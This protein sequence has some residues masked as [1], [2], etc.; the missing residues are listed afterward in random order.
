MRKHTTTSLATTGLLA[1]ALLVPAPAALADGNTLTVDVG[2][3]VRTVTRVGNGGLYALATPT[4][5]DPSL[6]PALH[7]NQL[8]QPPPGVQQLGNGATTPT[9]D[10]LKIGQT[11]V[12]AGAQQQ[13]RVPDIYPDFP[14]KWVSWDDLTA[15]VNT[16]VQQRLDRQDLTNVNGWELWN[17]PDWTWDTAKAGPF[18]DGFARIAKIVRAKDA[19]TPIVG[20]SFSKYDHDLMLSFMTAQKASGT[21]PDVAS[22]HELDDGG[23]NSVA[24]HVADYRAI[25]KQLGISPRPI[26]I[27]EYGS[28]NQVDDPSVAVHLV[29]AF[30]RSGVRDAERAY[31]YESGTIGGLIWNDKPTGSYWVYKW[32]ADQSGN[33]VKT[34]PSGDFDGVASYDAVR[35]TVNV[36]AGGVYGTNN[37]KINGLAPLGSQVQVTVNYTP[38]SGRKS[39]VDAP[40]QVSSSTYTVTNGSITVPIKDQDYLGA[41]QVLVTPVGGAV[42]TQ[43]YEAENAT[44]VN[45]ERLTSASAS[46]GG[47]V[48]R[49]DGTGDAR[50]DSF[51]DFVVNVPT[52]GK[53]TMGVRYAN[54]GT[55]T[56]TQGLAYNG[57]A[58]STISYP[59]TGSW[60]TFTTNATA[61]AGLDLKAGYNVIRLAK[62]S[63]NF[64]GG[65]GYAELD[66]ITLTKS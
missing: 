50:K 34:T 7:L 28:P 4:D 12:S 46:N 56:A 38:K 9:G 26:S 54:G 19:V 44:V 15:K 31:W 36:V 23:W 17:E 35:K 47:Y 41:Y 51:V 6:L 24:A 43:T 14:Y 61:S 39:N 16:M 49:I 18:N 58:F 8:T 55:S 2:S 63:P 10:A 27:N 21:V 25:E 52:A 29:A 64:A 37:V 5:P 20:P 65:S 3:S 22:W 59:P 62:G 30:E 40:T 45:A 13:I 60:G 11:A 66:S 53:Y 57:S 32:L 33:V 1:A 48:G 42:S